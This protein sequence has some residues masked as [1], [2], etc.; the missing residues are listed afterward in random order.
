MK[1]VRKKFSDTNLVSI[2]V[3]YIKVCEEAV[4]IPSKALWNWL[5]CNHTGSLWQNTIW[6][7]AFWFL[8]QPLPFPFFL[9]LWGCLG[10]KDQKMVW[11]LKEIDKVSSDAA[12]LNQL[13]IWWN[14]SSFITSDLFVGASLL[15]Y[16]RPTLKMGLPGSQRRYSRLKYWECTLWSSVCFVLVQDQCIIFSCF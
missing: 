3:E 5:V 16:S 4:F 8:V 2:S 12:C 14:L 6:T 13:C 9:F 7:C 1:H 10:E 15:L 11:S